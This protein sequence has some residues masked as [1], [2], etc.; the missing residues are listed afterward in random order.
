MAEEFSTI[1]ARL[2]ARWNTVFQERQIIFRSERRSRYFILSTRLQSTVAVALMIGG[3]VGL[4]GVVDYLRT[5][6]LV[7]RKDAAI[8]RAEVRYKSLLDQVADYRASMARTSET[9]RDKQESL[10]R[11]FE[12]NETLKAH[13][14]ITERQLELTQDE[15]ER[16]DGHREAMHEQLSALEVA[17][18]D[19]SQENIELEEGLNGLRSQLVSVVEENQVLVETRSDQQQRIDD[20]ESRL[21]QS[22]AQNQSLATE[23]KAMRM[24]MHKAMQARSRVLIEKAT[25]EERISALEAQLTSMEEEHRVR[26]Q[27]IAEQAMS[28]IG[29][30]QRILRAA[31]LNVQEILPPIAPVQRPE[32]GSDPESRLGQGGPFVPLLNADEIGDLP[33]EAR[34]VVPADRLGDAD[35]DTM[36]VSLDHYLGRLAILDSVMR[37]VPLA[38]PLD[39]YW[40]TSRFG[41]RRDP[42]NGKRARHNGIDLAGRYRAPV[43]ATAAGKVTK[44]GWMSGY[45]RI[46]E[47]DHGQGFKTRYAHLSKIL[48]KR[49]EEV[50]K[51]ESVGLLGSSGRSTGP[52]VHYEVLKD[53]RPINPWRFIKAGR[54]VLK[55]Q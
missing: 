1:S 10:S 48:V 25:A 22:Q 20:L 38:E 35:I 5:K 3:L 45:G 24:D 31:G 37:A 46:V 2:I 19:M 18:T 51:G 21:A 49:G 29:D 43:M 27:S 47:V 50:A 6:D 30:H 16:M 23:V 17:L 14:S 54:D 41:P 15:R 44:S 8:E 12:Q 26:L 34:R 42:I 11:L 28:T 53:D 52:H 4:G 7:D 13:L 36:L 40:L 33:P 9:L 32:I 39:E 55:V